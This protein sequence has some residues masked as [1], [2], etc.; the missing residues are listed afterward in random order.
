MG[1][2][3][4]GLWPDCCCPASAKAARLAALFN[5]AALNNARWADQPCCP[6][7]C[8]PTCFS[9]L[10]KCCSSCGQWPTQ[11]KLSM[12][13]DC[14]SPCSAQLLG[15]KGI[16]AKFNREACDFPRASSENWISSQACR[17]ME[18]R[19]KQLTLLIQLLSIFY[20]ASASDWKHPS[21]YKTP[22]CNF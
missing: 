10:W 5:L 4:L 9:C 1:I 21:A 20:L 13:S 16:Q 2:T 19:F 18:P 6:W 3:H 15:L 14:L 11:W 8:F 17:S 7:N 22:S 12:L